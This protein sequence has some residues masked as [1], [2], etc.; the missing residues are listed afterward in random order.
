[1]H[2][3]EGIPLMLLS[4]QQDNAINMPLNQA[5][6]CRPVT[7]MLSKHEFQDRR[8]DLHHH[9]EGAFTDG[10]LNSGSVFLGN[11]SVRGITHTHVDSRSSTNVLY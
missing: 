8:T 7:D 2:Q 9:I 11:G 6:A 3:P 1:M 4:L 5:A 10:W